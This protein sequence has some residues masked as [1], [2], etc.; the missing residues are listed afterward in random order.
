MNTAVWA[1]IME[2]NPGGFRRDIDGPYPDGKSYST[3]PGIILERL[4]QLPD[5][6]QFRF[7]GPHLILFDVRA[8]TIIDQLPNAIECASDCDE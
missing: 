5:D 6:I 4:P 8:S 3:M 2:E 1:V 7:V